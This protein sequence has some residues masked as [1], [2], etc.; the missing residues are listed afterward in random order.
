MTVTT[1]DCIFAIVHMYHYI[2]ATYVCWKMLSWKIWNQVTG[3][4]NALY[5]FRL[6]SVGPTFFIADI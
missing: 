3:M 6:A 5:I 2:L 1:D 4:E